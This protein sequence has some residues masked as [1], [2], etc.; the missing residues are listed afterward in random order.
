MNDLVNDCEI[1][2]LDAL[3]TG[4]FFPYLDEAAFFFDPIPDV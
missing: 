4:M 3:C 2:I 1:L